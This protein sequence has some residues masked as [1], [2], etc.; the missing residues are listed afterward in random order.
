MDSLQ[1]WKKYL[2][3]TTAVICSHIFRSVSIVTD[4][5]VAKNDFPAFHH[6]DEGLHLSS[7]VRL[8]AVVLVLRRL[9]PRR[10][11]GRPNS[12]SDF[13]PQLT[14]QMLQPELLTGMATVT[15]ILFNFKFNKHNFHHFPF[16]IWCALQ[17]SGELDGIGL[18]SILFLWHIPEKEVKGRKVW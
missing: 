11:K 18:F 5:L 15:K 16:I 13:L 9:W 2:F 17:N 14:F 12:E 7:K 3:P 10:W 1:N 8:V 4:R 6:V